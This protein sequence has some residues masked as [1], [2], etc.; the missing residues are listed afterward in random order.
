VNRQKIFSLIPFLLVA[1]FLLKCWIVI[2]SSNY[3]ATPRH[4]LGLILFSVLLFVLLKDEKRA[5]LGLGIY[6]LLATFN[7]LA[8][9]PVI[10][11]SWITI[12][13]SDLTTPPVQLLSLGLFVLYFTLTMDVLIDIQL[14]KKEAKERRIKEKS[15]S[16][17]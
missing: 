11:T 3:F 9:T 2:L 4:Y 10:T 16:R 15:D 12:G 6:L 17:I 5:I 14:D 13:S 1:G 7:L 8:I